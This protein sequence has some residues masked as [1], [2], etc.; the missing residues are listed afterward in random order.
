MSHLVAGIDLG[1]ASVKFVVLEAGF[2]RSRIVDVFEEAV[3]S[4]SEALL[5]RQMAAVAKGRER[6]K[7]ECSFFSALSGDQVAIRALELPFTDARKLGQVVP[8]ELEGQI[9]QPLEEVVFD[10]ITLSP[11]V[12]A[13]SVVAVAAPTD[14]VGA[15]LEAF[16]RAGVSLRALYVGPLCLKGDV[17]NVVASDVGVTTTVSDD[18]KNHSLESEGA[19][20]ADNVEALDDSENESNDPIEPAPVMGVLLNVGGERT[21]VVLT[22]NGVP[23]I[24]RTIRRG[25]HHLIGALAQ[26]FQATEAQA[27][28]ALQT[29]AVIRHA[30]FNPKDDLE[31]RMAQVLDSALAPLMRDVRQTLASFRSQGAG[32]VATVSL[33]GEFQG[34]NGFHQALSEQ[35]GLPFEPFRPAR[36]PGAEESLV[37]PTDP[38]FALAESIAWAG[39]QGIRML[40]LR[41][42]PH[43]Y[44]ASF[45]VLRNKAVH[46]GI[47]AAAL[48]LCFVINGAFAFAKLEKQN[49][50][51]KKDL[52]T[53][54][55]EL[56]GR[57]D[58]DAARVKRTMQI[59]FREELPPIPKATAYDVFF[60]ISQR[61]PGPDEVTIDLTELDIREKKTYMKGLIDS[62][63]SVD[64][65]VDEL[66]TFDCFGEMAKGA[67]TEVSGGEKQF[68][69]TIKSSCP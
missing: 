10:H 6:I 14:A 49:E 43:V 48:A 67:I 31:E 68:T 17:P 3:E 2:R 39:T 69:L 26:A 54:T 15:F 5:D 37:E 1:A 33:V 11:P 23:V 42:G 8:Y 24:A 38:R 47:L 55:A 22:R 34:L 44:K 65:V 4:G 59:G 61:M 28:E 57:A 56:F 51:L 32:D 12:G 64:K 45:S 60:E 16:E 13:A 41:R 7:G 63:A 66:E 35:L 52:S 25:T 36:G 46:L 62:V 30:G 20:E 29:R 50:K 53:A 19:D 40:D 9:V 21:D 27:A 58:E 18:S